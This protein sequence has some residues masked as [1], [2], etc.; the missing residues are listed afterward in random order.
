MPCGHLLGKGC[1]L[2]S[3]LWCL[4]M[5]LS[6][7]FWYPGSGVVLYCIDPWSLH[8]YLLSYVMAVINYCILIWQT[9]VSKEI[10]C[11]RCIYTSLRGWQDAITS[12]IRNVKVQDKINLLFFSLFSLANQQLMLI[13]IVDSNAHANVKRCLDIVIFAKIYP[14]MII[15]NT[16]TTADRRQSKTLLTIDERGSKITRNSFF[17]CHLSQVGWQMAINFLNYFWSTFTDSINVF[18]C[19]LSSVVSTAFAALKERKLHQ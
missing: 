13:A 14:A 7:S 16:G 4:N 2:G 12:L 18:D 10:K 3:R 11:R 8:P 1:P 6:L 17:D 5:S 9:S 15:L 19:R